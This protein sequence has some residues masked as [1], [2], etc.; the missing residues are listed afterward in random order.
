MSMFNRSVK[1]QFNRMKYANL[2]SE[3][4]KNLCQYE[5]KIFI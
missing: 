1:L 3:G 5:S 2:K 4:I